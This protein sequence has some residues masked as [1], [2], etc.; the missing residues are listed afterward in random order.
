MNLGSTIVLDGTH[1]TTEE[2][3]AVAK[4]RTEV[5]LSND[6]SFLT[7]LEKSRQTLQEAMARGESVYGITTGFGDS[8]TTRVEM[9]AGQTLGRNLSRYHR[10]GVGPAMTS[11]ESRSVLFARLVALSQGMSAVRPRV[12]EHL[13]TML[14]ADVTPVIPTR[15]SVGASGDLTP[16]SYI[17][18]ALLGEGL[19]LVDNGRVSMA[20]AQKIRGL[21]PLEIDARETLAIMNGTSAMAG[22]GALAIERS[23]RVLRWATAL[24]AMTLEA[25]ESDARQFHPRVARAKAHRGSIEIAEAL[26]SDLTGHRARAGRLQERYS[27]RCTPQ[28]LGVALDVWHDSQRYTEGELNGASDNP[29]FDPDGTIF[30]GGNFYGGHIC[31]A[32]DAL[33]AQLA[34]VA[35]LLER[36]L[37]LLCSPAMSEG[38]P[39]NLV[40]NASRYPERH[41]FK[42]AQITASA[43]TAEA[44]KSAMPASVL[45]RSTENH[46]QDKVSMGMLATRDCLDVLELVEAV[47]A[48]VT[49]AVAQALEIRSNGS[50]TERGAAM[51]SALRARVPAVEEDRPMDV[52]VDAVLA[53]FEEDALPIGA[54]FPS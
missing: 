45:S 52:D 4:K 37:I 31:Q 32:M 19:A 35:D 3:V 22:L 12:L 38:L 42:A 39:P 53:L 51:L 44:I 7:R 5:R 14:N 40:R 23:R 34:N 21:S 49:L 24:S 26:T 54:L 11:I 30:H 18:A 25:L 2:V 41:G 17:A 13:A 8:V 47:A 29:L 36:Q 28:V 33:R 46:N 10:I 43:L 50:Q 48:I 27:V 1:V 15:G 16:L 6:P 9:N 20:E